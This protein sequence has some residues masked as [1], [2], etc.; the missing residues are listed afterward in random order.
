MSDPV[1]PI[2][3]GLRRAVAG[4]RPAPADARLRVRARLEAA[5]PGMAPG[6]ATPPAA[7]APLVPANRLTASLM[8]AFLVGG[9]TGAVLL[10]V[11]E[12]RPAPRV[13]YVDRVV[14]G[15]AVAAPVRAAETVAVPG[16]VVPDVARPVAARVVHMGAPK[17][18]DRPAPAT[19]VSPF[20]AERMLLDEARAAIVQGAPDRALD[21]LEQH[22]A[23]FPKGLLAEERDAMAIEALV[24]AGR[25]D[26][27][28]SQAAAFRERAP[29]SLFVAT[30]DSAIASIP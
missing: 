18:I 30:V 28:R 22:R 8:A 19:R 26:E 7:T 9:V 20:A 12:R 13:V 21:R 27:A 14:E 15:P 11:L 10:G 24:N 5:V 4:E 3:F 2:D 25:Y 29:G 16:V 17:A 1:L 23:R 6:V